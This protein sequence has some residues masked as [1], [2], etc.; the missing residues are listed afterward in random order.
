[1]SSISDMVGVM[2]GAITN[3]PSL[4]AA[5]QTVLQ[6]NSDAYNVSEAMSMG[7]AAAYPLGVVGI[8]LTMIVIKAIFKVNIDLAHAFGLGTGF[9]IGLALLNPI[10]T[11]IL[12][13]GDAAYYGSPDLY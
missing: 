8:I 7:Y 12:G 5:Q 3:T 10:F 2:C 6:V 13:F 1:M 11:C 9:G 4:G